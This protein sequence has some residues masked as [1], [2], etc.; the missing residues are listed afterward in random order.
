[1]HPAQRRLHILDAL[2]VVGGA[3]A[4]LGD[5]QR[6]TARDVPRPAQTRLQGLGPELVAHERGAG[7]TRVRH[8]SVG[9]DEHARVHLHAEEVVAFGG[10]EEH[11]LHG[12]PHLLHPG[13][14]AVDGLVVGHRERQANGYTGRGRADGVDGPPVALDEDVVGLVAPFRG[15]LSGREHASSVPVEGDH[16]GLVDRAG[17]AQHVGQVPGR[18]RAEAGEALGGDG[19]GPP[20]GTRH[21]VG[22]V[23]GARPCHRA[24]QV[25]CGALHEAGEAVR[26]VGNGPSP[27][28][29]HPAGRREV[30][31]GDDGLDPAFEARLAHPLVVVERHQRELTLFGLDAAPLQRE[32]IGAKAQVGKEAEVVRPAVPMIDRVAAGLHAR[33]G[34][35][36]L[37][38]PP[39]VVPGT[40]VDLVSGRC[41]A[42]REPLGKRLSR[43]SGDNTRQNLSP[44]LSFGAARRRPLPSRNRPPRPRPRSG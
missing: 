40:P 8:R 16:V 5:E 44:W 32:A 26:G 38:R 13:L 42:P 2:G 35:I 10:V 28:R 24:V 7:A 4:V 19:V 43:H 11:V 25:R 14:A 20:T 21:P 37:P 17:G 29:R 34:R 22:L 9:P 6:Q 41:R 27:C 1:M 23:D 36:V 15:P 30:M 39:I 18:P 31:E 33:R 12:L 3:D